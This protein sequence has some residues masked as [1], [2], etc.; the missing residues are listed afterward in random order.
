MSIPSLTKPIAPAPLGGPREPIEWTFDPWSEGVARPLAAVASTLGV[1]SL[2]CFSRLPLPACTVLV[3]GIVVLMAPG[4]VASRFRIDDAG[5]S[6]RVAF[7]P[8]SQMPWDRVKSATLRR[9]GLLVEARG[10][11]GFLANLRTWA[12]PLPAKADDGAARERLLAWRDAR[13]NNDG[14]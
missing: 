13:R 10:A 8:W 5:V 9:R 3:L 14:D 6:R 4:F 11:L 1:V 12:L 7:L 2:A